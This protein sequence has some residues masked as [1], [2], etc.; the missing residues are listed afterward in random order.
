[1]RLGKW[2]LLGDGVAVVACFARSPATP[3]SVM[4]YARGRN[5]L[6]EASSG[7]YRDVMELRETKDG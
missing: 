7:L 2:M 6:D 3:R 5:L 4:D 1:M